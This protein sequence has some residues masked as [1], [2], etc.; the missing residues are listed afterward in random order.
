MHF[1]IRSNAEIFFKDLTFLKICFSLSFVLKLI[2]SL[3]QCLLKG[4][5][6][7]RRTLLFLY[8]SYKI[9]YGESIFYVFLKLKIK[10]FKKIKQLTKQMQ[11]IS[12]YYYIGIV[13]KRNLILKNNV[14]I[15]F[16]NSFLKP[17]MFYSFASNSRILLMQVLEKFRK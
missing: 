8:K 10:D 16:W 11:N 12:S 2:F 4:N 7:P 14:Y 3:V 17:F 5:F 6:T 13:Y 1:L 15:L 9:V